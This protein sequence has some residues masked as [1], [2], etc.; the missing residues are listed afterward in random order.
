MGVRACLR[1]AKLLESS[2]AVVDR[3]LAQNRPA[4]G[5]FYCS[6]NWRRPES[7]LNSR[8][9]RREI[10]IRRVHDPAKE[11]N[12]AGLLFADQQDK[13]MIHAELRGW[14]YADASV[15]HNSSRGR[16]LRAFFVCL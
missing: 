14:S 2:R 4:G 16:G 10:S 8:A 6:V 5:R 3:P 11:E 13:W 1:G 9:Y 12:A 7:L 15:H